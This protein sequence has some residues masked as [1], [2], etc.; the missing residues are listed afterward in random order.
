MGTMKAR[1]EIACNHQITTKRYS[2]GIK[3]KICREIQE[4]TKYM[5]KAGSWNRNMTNEDHKNPSMDHLI[6]F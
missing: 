1:R 6:K 5:E 4:F 2:L 3:D